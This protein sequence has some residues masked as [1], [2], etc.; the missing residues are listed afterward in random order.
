MGRLSSHV[1]V[2]PEEE[3]RGQDHVH[4]LSKLVERRSIPVSQRPD[5]KLFDLVAVR[6]LV[7]L[8]IDFALDDKGL[9]QLLIVLQNKLAATLK[10]LSRHR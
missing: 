5:S 7:N 2:H 8:L 4:Q 9:R 6:C 10:Y 1:H 3:K